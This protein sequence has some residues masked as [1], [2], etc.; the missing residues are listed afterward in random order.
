MSAAGPCAVRVQE[1]EDLLVGQAPS[2]E[3]IL[4]HHLA[5]RPRSTITYQRGDGTRVSGSGRELG[6]ELSPLVRRLLPL[7]SMENEWGPGQVECTF[8]PQSALRTADDL[9]LF[10]TATRQ[11][12]RR[13]G[14][15]ATFM[16][17]QLSRAIARAAGTCT[18][19][20]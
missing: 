18:S 14:C 2:A 1:A 20:W 5:A 12:C 8:G 9:V 15:F 4:R 10:R 17:R 6:R 11:V 7:R 3:A 19:L 16:A 13:M